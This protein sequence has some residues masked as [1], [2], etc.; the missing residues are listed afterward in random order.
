M[1]PD[2]NRLRTFFHVRHEGS[3]SKAAAALHVTQSAVSQALGKLEHEIGTQ[4]FVRRHRKLVPTPAGETLYALVKPFLASLDE[5]LEQLKR[6]K[7]EVAG[8]LRV[9]A[10]VEFGSRRLPAAFAAFRREHPGVSFELTLGHPTRLL[11][12]LD[13]GSLDMAFADIF[14]ARH[15]GAPGQA[16]LDIIKVMDEQL[17][18]VASKTYERKHLNGARSFEEIECLDFIAYQRGAPGLHT[19]FKHH[20]R[21]L[22][23]GLN[24]VFAVESV[25]AV[26]AGAQQSMGLGLVP[27]HTVATLLERGPLT[28]I[29][30]R[31][32]ELTNRV[33]L[34]R[35]LDKVPS[36]AERAFVKS[37]REAL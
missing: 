15:E 12:L 13:R 7:H 27:L 18:V 11:P 4:L 29:K 30:T 3:V 32:R 8:L 10:P 9:G 16:G 2:L 24:V 1:L 5:G 20:F 36:P 6:A 25:Q 33:S 21:K 34:A 22:P 37:L 31:R 26:I 14:T 19:W 17:V 35:M 23:K 28:H